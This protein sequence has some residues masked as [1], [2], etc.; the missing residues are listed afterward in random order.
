MAKLLLVE[1]DNNLREIYQARLAA[2]GYDIVAAQNGEEALVVAKQ[3][4]P[5]L[6]ISDVMM[7]R[8]SGFEMLDILRNTPELRDT[9]VIMLTALGQA[10]DQARAGKL[11]ADKYLVKSQVT[12]EDIVKCAEDLI[13]GTSAPAPTPPPA[14]PAEP[15]IAPATITPVI[16]VTTTAPS[17]SAP[18][19]VTATPETLPTPAPTVDPIPP[20]PAPNAV[21]LVPGPTP[22]PDDMAPAA[23]PIVSV[24]DPDPLVQ[25]S[26]GPAIV[27]HSAPMMTEDPQAAQT[28]T[29][30]DNTIPGVSENVTDSSMST[31]VTPAV[32]QTTEA[33]SSAQTDDTTP[34]TNEIPIVPQTM[35]NEEAVIESQIEAFA[36]QQVSPLFPEATAPETAAPPESPT[37][38]NQAIIDNVVN[39]LHAAADTPP[40]PLL[41]PSQQV[42]PGET[43][44]VQ[45]ASSGESD[46]PTSTP[47]EN[48]ANV[49]P[50][51]P[52]QAP[53]PVVPSTLE[54]T[55][56][57]MPASVVITPTQ[58]TEND[59]VEVAGK[60]VIKP[61]NDISH[62]PDLNDL[63]AKE[64]AKETAAIANGAAPVTVGNVTPQSN[65]P[66]KLDPNS[67][68]L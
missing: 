5:D 21:P 14:E 41:P 60:K 68:A 37:A 28:P 31:T 17:T 44:P 62:G 61:I 38:S 18:T 65:E 32:P 4:H 1:D 63:L 47:V 20:T 42:V 25:A 51:T 35:A 45:A 12:L 15:Q 58:Q 16:P 8:I 36:G 9:K 23:A 30:S 27:T 39:E 7:P 64:A 3:Q 49:A 59:Q 53:E 48:T 24:P 46:Q 57:T 19:G 34:T 50:N 56:A 52:E 29:A 43:Q 66:S 26:A 10:E 6:I 22:A 2:E 33:Y 55:S 11:G 13:N 54:T 40:A 67:I